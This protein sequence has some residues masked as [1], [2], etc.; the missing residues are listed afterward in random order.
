VIVDYRNANTPLVLTS[1]SVEVSASQ[2]VTAMVVSGGSIAPTEPV[3]GNTLDW[4]PVDGQPYVALDGDWAVMPDTGIQ[5]PPSDG[6]TYAAKDGAWVVF[7]PPTPGII[8]NTEELSS[9]IDGSTTHFTLETAC[10]SVEVFINGL[11]QS[12][13]Y[14]EMDEDG[15]GFT[16][17][18]VLVSGDSLSVNKYEN[19]ISVAPTT[20]TDVLEISGCV[21]CLDESHLDWLAEDAP[22][23]LWDDRSTAVNDAFQS[24]AARKPIKKSAIVNSYPVAR[25]DNS[26]DSLETPVFL[27]AYPYTIAV[28]Y[29][30]SGVN[31]GDQRT[32]NGSGAAGEN[33]WLI[34][35]YYGNTTLYNGDFVFGAAPTANVFQLAVVKNN[36]LRVNGVSY[37]SNASANV[38]GILFLG[39]NNAYGNTGACDIACVVV[40]DRLLSVNETDALETFLM[41]KYGIV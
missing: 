21:L 24:D 37:G 5:F 6:Q 20:I 27:S 14:A 41:N 23:S 31:F 28:V 2:P 25:F 29:A 13:S 38:P 33:N 34:G 36:S 3:N 1:G 18:D 4:P 9:Q 22:L 16:I 26:N 17:E 39:Q 19:A 15:L 8:L 12:I 30:I 7:T 10:A 11:R 35:T 32:L 40:Y